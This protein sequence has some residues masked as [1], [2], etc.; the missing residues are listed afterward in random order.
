MLLSYKIDPSGFILKN[1]Q[2]LLNLLTIQ[3]QATQSGEG[4]VAIILLTLT[5]FSI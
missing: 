2:T 5:R 4:I 1:Y 3:L